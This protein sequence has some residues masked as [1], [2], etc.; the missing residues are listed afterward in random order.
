MHKVENER[1]ARHFLKLEDEIETPV[2]NEKTH[3]NHLPLHIDINNV[4][5][6]ADASFDV[7]YNIDEAAPAIMIEERP[8]VVEKIIPVIGRPVDQEQKIGHSATAVKSEFKAMPNSSVLPHNSSVDDFWMLVSSGYIPH[9]AM[10]VLS[11]TLSRQTAEHD[12]ATVKSNHS[13]SHNSQAA[14]STVSSKKKRA[15]DPPTA[16]VNDACAHCENNGEDLQTGDMVSEKSIKLSSSGLVNKSDETDKEGGEMT[17]TNGHNV[18]FA[19]STYAHAL[20][21]VVIKNENNP[22]FIHEQMQSNALQNLYFPANFDYVNSSSHR[23]LNHSTIHYDKNH[24]MLFDKRSVADDTNQS[25]GRSAM[26]VE[27]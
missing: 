18:S 16:G 6:S 10:N 5:S 7:G 12:A 11:E 8:P 17:E 24:A 22:E 23:I 25:R 1:K 13:Q 19:Y 3:I 20:N 4:S 14:N 2:N 27:S 21:S 15:R 26:D 9:P